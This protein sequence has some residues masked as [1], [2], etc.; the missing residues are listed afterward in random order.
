VAQK[1]DQYQVSL[2]QAIKDGTDAVFKRFD[3]L[4]AIMLGET[5]KYR[6]QHDKTIPEIIE[7]RFG[8]AGS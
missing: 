7:E 5:K 3:D 1:L 4:T 8:N 2:D 6:S